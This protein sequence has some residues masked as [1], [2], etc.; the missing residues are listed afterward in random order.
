[1]FK[2]SVRYVFYISVYLSGIL[3][4]GIYTPAVISYAKQFDTLNNAE[5]EQIQQKQQQLKK[6]KIKL[7]NLA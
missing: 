2:R 6:R 3:I 4:G 7:K 5:Q 1:M